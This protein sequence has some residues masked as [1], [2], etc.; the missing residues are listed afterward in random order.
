VTVER[1]RAALAKARLQAIQENPTAVRHLR[2]SRIADGRGG[3]TVARTDA[4]EFTARVAPLGGSAFE[5]EVARRLVAQALWSVLFP[6]S[7][8]VL[9]RLVASDR[10]YEVVALYPATS[11]SAD[12]SG[13]ATLAVA[14]EVQA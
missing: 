7:L 10:A 1:M 5:Q 3:E 13:G 6:G 4:G 11:W 9:D 2:A 14:R 12:P 8:A